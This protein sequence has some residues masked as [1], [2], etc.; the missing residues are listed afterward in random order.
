[1]L[2]VLAQM[3]VQVQLASLI[4]PPNS[5]NKAASSVHRE[6]PPY[7]PN[8]REVCLFWGIIKRPTSKHQ[9]QAH[10][11]S[12][13]LAEPLNRLVVF[14]AAKRRAL[15]H[16]SPARHLPISSKMLVAVA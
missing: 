14:L 12:P 8:R 6:I 10:R 2:P 13:Y 3:L 1:M 16:Q 15:Q 11:L 5:S 4:D 9:P 7:L